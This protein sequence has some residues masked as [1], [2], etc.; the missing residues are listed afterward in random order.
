MNLSARP[1]SLEEIEHIAIQYK[2]K[3]TQDCE[4]MVRRNDHPGALAAIVGKEYIDEFV[5]RLKLRAGSQM[6]LPPRARPIQL[7]VARSGRGRKRESE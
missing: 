1:L 2:E 4:R 6:G 7:N 3:L 5:Y